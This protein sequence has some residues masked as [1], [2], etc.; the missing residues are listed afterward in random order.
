M[1]LDVSDPA[2]R[3]GLQAADHA[4]PL[5]FA[6]LL[7]VMLLAG[8]GWLLLR[9]VVH[10]H[11]PGRPMPPMQLVLR[12]GLGALGI[13]AAAT[14]FA[15]LADEMGDGEGLGRF[16]EAVAGRLAQTLAPAVLRVFA[17]I[18]HL[19]DV[20]MLTLVS[21]AAIGWL[22]WQRRWRMALAFGLVTGGGG[23]LNRVLKSVFERVR[24]PHEHGVGVVAD[25]YSFPS[26]HSAGSA[27]VYG[28]LAWLLL[29]STPRHWHAPIVAAAAAL[30]FTIGVSRVML[31][32]HWAS[33]VAAGLASGTAWLLTCVLIIDWLRRPRGT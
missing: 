26:G 19:G 15:E 29:R 33:D 23:L 28:M 2:V 27:V 5:Y 22:L 30:V 4:L 12:L 25:G 3:L 18:T 14:A 11:Q 8:G 9:R 32:V 20:I 13:V 6:G 10:P 1:T 31:Q 7:A 16:D 21:L 24:P 17:T